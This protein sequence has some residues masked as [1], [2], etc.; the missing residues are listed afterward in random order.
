LRTAVRVAGPTLSIAPDGRIALN[1][2]AVRLFLEAGAKTTALL[3]W[4]KSNYRMALKA[5]PKSD[6]DVLAISLSGIHSA[7][8]R[9]KGFLSHIGWSAPERI[10]MAATWVE[11]GK[12]LEVRLPAEYLTPKKT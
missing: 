12:M 9:A 8:V 11:S 7:V 5:A 3:L 6:R 10:S 2:A 4:D 1:A